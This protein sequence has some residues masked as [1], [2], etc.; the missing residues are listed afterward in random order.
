ADMAGEALVIV[1]HR[2]F[3]YLFMRIVTGHATNARVGGIVTAAIG[4]PV[5]LEANVVDIVRTVGGD[6]R[7]GAVAFSAKVRQF[8]SRKLA[9]LAHGRGSYVARSH[10]LQVAVRLA[11]TAFALYSRF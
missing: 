1:R 10:G 6:L 11:V 3:G 9:E 8:L 2:N 4:Q 7:P 5:G